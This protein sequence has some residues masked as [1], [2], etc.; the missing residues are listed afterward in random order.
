MC[1]VGVFLQKKRYVIHVL[2]D[3]DIPTNKFKYTGVEV[4]RSTMPAPI[5]PYVKKIIE[6]VQAVSYRKQ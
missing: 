4:V 3:E 5:K 1:D 6:T 2:D